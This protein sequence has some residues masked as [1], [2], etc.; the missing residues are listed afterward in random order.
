MGLGRDSALDPLCCQIAA[1]TLN[2]LRIA[3]HAAAPERETP[4]GC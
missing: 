4:P 2:R 1:Q 3:A